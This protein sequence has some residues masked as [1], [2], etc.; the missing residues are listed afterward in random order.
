LS[1]LRDAPLIGRY[2]KVFDTED[3]TSQVRILIWQGR[4][5]SWCARIRRSTTRMAAQISP[6]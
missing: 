3:R 4:L 1:S 2:S 5:G 6:T